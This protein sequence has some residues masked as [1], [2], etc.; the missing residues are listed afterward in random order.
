MLVS[1]GPTGVGREGF[2]GGCFQCITGEA[3]LIDR[4]EVRQGLP[5]WSPAHE[6]ATLDLPFPNAPDIFT[7]KN[8][9]AAPPFMHLKHHPSNNNS[10]YSI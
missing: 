9:R 7:S 1:S 4:R 2:R 6:M 5:T 10:Y 3:K 8:E